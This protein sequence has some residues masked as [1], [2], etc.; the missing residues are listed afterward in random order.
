[1]TKSDEHQQKPPIKVFIV[2]DHPVVRHGLEQLISAE[3]DLR[4]CGE[5]EG[6]DEAFE[7]ID[8]ARPDIVLIDLALKNGN[9]MELIHRISSTWVGL[10]MIVVS[11][12]DASAYAPSVLRAGAMGYINK[13][14][15]ID[16]IITAIRC[17]LRGEMFAGNA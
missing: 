12:Y 11:S 9:G 13:H 17:V 10:K 4:V 2:E 6:A 7:R 14:E 1:M 3:S 8:A 5:A 16:Q 15:A